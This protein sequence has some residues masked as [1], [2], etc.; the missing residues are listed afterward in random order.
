MFETKSHLFLVMELIEGGELFDRIVDQGTFSEKLAAQITAQILQGVKY[1]HAEGVVHRDLK[2]ENIL[3]ADVPGGKE[4]D[5]VCKIADFGLSRLMDKQGVLET[6]CGTPNYVA[7]E[8]LYATGYGPSVDLWAVGVILYI[9]LSG[10]WPFDAEN[11]A[12]LY[13]QIMGGRYS[14]PDSEWK[15]IS[16]EAKDMVR[17]LLTVDPKKRLDALQALQHPWLRTHVDEV[18]PGINNRFSNFNVSQKN[19]RG[20]P[21]PEDRMTVAVH[22]SHEVY[23][24]EDNIVQMSEDT[25]RDGGDLAGKWRDDR[26]GPM[27]LNGAKVVKFKK[28]ETILAEGSVNQHFLRIKSGEVRAEKAA[29]GGG[30]VY[31]LHVMK[32]PEMFGEISL[33]QPSGLVS[34]SIVANTDV[35]M[36]MFTPK[37]LN[38]L[39]QNEHSLCERF[40]KYLAVKQANRLAQSRRTIESLLR[41]EGKDVPGDVPVPLTARTAPALDDPATVTK[42]FK[43]YSLSEKSE[44]LKQIFACK[45]KKSSMPHHGPVFVTDR[46]LCFS[47]TVFAFTQRYLVPL[48]SIIDVEANTDKTELRVVVKKK[49][50]ETKY[51][52]LFTKD[53]GSKA[54]AFISQTWKEGLEGLTASMANLCD[55]V[56]D[57]GNTIVEGQ[58]EGALTKDDWDL[59]LDEASV[60]HYEPNEV[61]VREGDPSHKLYQIFNGKCRVE[62]TRPED[63]KLIVVGTLNQMEIFGDISFLQKGSA[64]ASVLADG[65]TD[66]YVIDGEYI[67]K[68]C[69]QNPGLGG[70]FFKHLA[71]VISQRLCRREEKLLA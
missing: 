41:K 29:A 67:S 70:R 26:D 18:I 33:L 46:F 49:G 15:Y 30:Q 12:E 13:D 34:V 61:I 45:W 50:K 64:T 53:V 1:L 48:K 57:L 65:A 31:V 42:F 27:L 40:Y 17:G 23:Q 60:K 68:L 35:E 51:T 11:A 56:S 3:V 24:L 54:V 71:T 59:I 63:D 55:S 37:F 4:N 52:F 21:R 14:F 7:P 22:P 8:V 32:A 28:N 5:I 2:P 16:K 25:P 66:I 44:T 20:D 6:A 36:Y 19:K 43:M 69:S 38:T 58:L 9:L 10:F 62:I 47:S 39:F